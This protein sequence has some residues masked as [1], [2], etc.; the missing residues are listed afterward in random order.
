MKKIILVFSL[1]SIIFSSRGAYANDPCDDK[2][3]LHQEC[4]DEL[5]S[6]GLPAPAPIGLTEK[7]R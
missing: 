4:L 3:L 5:D 6:L 1:L 2:K 7:K